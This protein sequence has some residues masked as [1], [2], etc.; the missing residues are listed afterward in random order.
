MTELKLV[1]L[2]TGCSNPTA[3]RNLSAIGLRFM[4]NW[5][6][7]DCGEGTQRQM[8]KA[9]VSYMKVKYIFFSHFHADHFLGF[10]GMVATMSM[11]ERDYPL[12][13]FGPKGTRERI[14]RV[15]NL[16]LMRKDFEIRVTEVARA[17]KIVEEENFEVT[18]FPLYSLTLLQLAPQ[19]ALWKK[20][21]RLCPLDLDL[22]VLFL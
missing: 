2:G 22:L 3:E 12:H 6:L 4:G 14:K 10:P 11:H 5:L 18:A 13:V 1:F 15:L 19:R 8:M 16:G 17:G 9:N 20:L 21:K 7:F